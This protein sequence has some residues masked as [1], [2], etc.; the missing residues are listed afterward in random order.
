MADTGWRTDPPRFP[1]RWL[2]PALAVI[3]VTAIVGI[4]RYPGLHARLPASGGLTVRTPASAFAVLIGQGYVTAMWTGLILLAYRSRPDLDA[5]DPAGSAAR[6]RQFLSQL[7]KAVLAL[8]TSVNL[9]LLLAGLRTWQLLPL[10]GSAA[11]LMLAP[12]AAGL[13]IVAIV[14]TR[15]GQGGFRLTPATAP[16]SGPG[17]ADRDD[18]RHWKAGL[19]MSTAATRPCWSPQFGAGWTANLEP[20]RLA[21]HRNDHRR[22]G[23]PCSHPPGIEP[24][25]RL[26]A[27]PQPR[28]PAAGSSSSKVANTGE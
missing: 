8:V 4:L 26:I 22:P 10:T 20:S 25:C 12:F 17:I 7:A 9:S 5:A 15:T 11:A 27:R 24:H 2:C 19:S 1:L 6:Y 21:P 14:L 18:D 3:A 23:R 28:S 13:L 16:P